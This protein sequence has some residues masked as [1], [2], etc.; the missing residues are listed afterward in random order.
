LDGLARLAALLPAV[1]R[2][3]ET[4]SMLLESYCEVFGLELGAEGPDFVARQG[5]WFDLD[6]GSSD[7]LDDCG[8]VYSR[9]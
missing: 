4:R 6:R 9:A 2:F 7:A 5:R 3:F 1:P 8:G